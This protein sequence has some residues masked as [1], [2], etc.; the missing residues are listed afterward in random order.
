MNIKRF[1]EIF[2]VDDTVIKEH[3]NGLYVRYEDYAQEIAALRN[4]L[5]AARLE[6]DQYFHDWAALSQDDGKKDREIERL[7]QRCQAMGWSLYP[8]SDPPREAVAGD[9]GWPAEH[10]SGDGI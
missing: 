9:I 2:G 1:A 8:H 5:T 6:R 4:D 3:P 7:N 10:P